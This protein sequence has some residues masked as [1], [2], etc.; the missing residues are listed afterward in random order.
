[1][2]ICTSL[3]AI[4]NAIML[5]CF[6]KKKM[7]IKFSKV[8]WHKIGAQLTGGT[9]TYFFLLILSDLYW[10]PELG[11]QSIKWLIYFGF[12]ICAV[13]VFFITTVTTL[14]LTGQSQW[15]IWKK[16]AW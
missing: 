2:A 12:L 8:F 11:T 14:Y 3:S 9:I 4:S 16:E 6:A 13:V 1:L 7:P 5:I 15:K 10:Y